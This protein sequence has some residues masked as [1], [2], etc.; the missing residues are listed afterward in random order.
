MVITFALFL[1]A[2][3]IG[4]FKA[5]GRQNSLDRRGVRAEAV[6]V[7]TDYQNDTDFLIVY[8]EPCACRLAI[9]TSNPSGHAVGS[10]LPVRYDPERPST[11][12][13]LVDR[14]NP[15][16]SF[17]VV[18]VSVMGLLL[19]AVPIVVVALRRQRRSRALLDTSTPN[20]IVRVEVWRRSLMGNEVAY[21]SAYQV[22]ISPGGSPILCMPVTEEI[23]VQIEGS[24][25]PPHFEVFGSAVPGQPLALRRGE[26][27]VTPGGRTKDAAWE[28]RHRP[29]PTAV[30]PDIRGGLILENVAEARSVARLQRMLQ[31]VFVALIPASL[32]R[33][34]PE[35]F[36]SAGLVVVFVLLVLVVAA[37]W[38]HRRLLDRFGRRLV[39]SA[40][41]RRDRRAA[42]SAAVRWLSSPG[43]KED[44]AS[45]LGVTVDERDASNRRMVRWIYAWL[46]LT[47]VVLVVV[48][49]QFAVS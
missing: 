18:L 45:L 7:G 41:G 36:L 20:G 44:M 46:G 2:P 9:A 3:A 32:I 14:P 31:F 15:Y 48:L 43:G 6:I 17:L 38:R 4:Y 47:V 23:A 11:A 19:I 34:V 37:R 24:D 1:A 8:V 49:V 39:G 13:A 29:S 25:L 22:D 27:A 35:R 26:L 33:V 28:K 10:T 40:G 21:L 12:E 5:K 30:T 16:E 42:R